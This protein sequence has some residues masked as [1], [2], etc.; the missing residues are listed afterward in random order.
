M[1][2]PASIA[3]A[4]VIV[5]ASSSCS[6]AVRRPAI[7]AGIVVGSL[8]LATCSLTTGIDGDA[9]TPGTDDIGSS[10]RAKCYGVSA[11]AGIGIALIAAFALWIGYEDET[12]PAPGAPGGKPVGDPTNLPPAPVFV[13]RPLPRPEPK[14]EP[15]KPEPAP[16]PAPDAPPPPP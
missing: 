4:S 6:F 2:F 10:P 8:G 9:S 12:T 5:I 15:P 16:E 1:R 13:P 11:G 3:I 7:T 14:P